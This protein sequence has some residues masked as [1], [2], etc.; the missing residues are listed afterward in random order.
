MQ[1]LVG[2]FWA[3]GKDEL[4]NWKFISCHPAGIVLVLKDSERL[5]GTNDSSFFFVAP[6]AVDAVGSLPISPSFKA[7]QP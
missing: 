2:N 6:S 5:L 3:S 4:E 1:P 7:L